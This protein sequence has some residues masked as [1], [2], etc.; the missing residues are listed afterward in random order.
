MHDLLVPMPAN[1]QQQTT[2]AVIPT[3]SPKLVPP[4]QPDFSPK[5]RCV[6]S[7]TTFVAAPRQTKPELSGGLLKL[8]DTLSPS[9]AKAYELVQ[10]DHDGTALNLLAFSNNL[11][12]A[13]MKK[14]KTP[15]TRP[16]Q[17]LP[18]LRSGGF[19]IA[20]TGRAA[21]LKDYFFNTK[22]KNAD[23]ESNLP[24]VLSAEDLVR[25]YAFDVFVSGRWYSLCSRLGS[26]HFT[27]TATT[28]PLV[29]EGWVSNPGVS[30]GTDG[31]SPD[32]KAHEAI[33]RWNG[34][35]LVAQRPGKTATVDEEPGYVTNKAETEFKVEITYEAAPDTLPPLR[36]GRDYHMRARAVDLAG[37]S[38]DAGSPTLADF[39]HALGDIYARFDPVS[40]PVLLM[41]APLTSSESLEHVVIRS[42]FDPVVGKALPAERHVAP[43]KVDEYMAEL[44]GMFDTP[45]GMNPGTYAA[46]V[47]RED[48]SFAEKDAQGNYVHPGA[49]KDD[50][51]SA[52]YF[53]VDSLS[54]P[55]EGGGSAKVPYLPDP[56]SRGVSFR[57]LPGLPPGQV[58][59][60]AFVQQGSGIEWPNTQP[61]RIRL[62]EGDLG[63]PTIL[64]GSVLEIIVPKA[65]VF[66]V[67][68]SSYLG[69]DDLT[70]MGI[71]QWITTTAGL[72][73]ADK[74]TLAKNATDGTHWM[75]TP[76]RKLFFVH[77]VRQPL[78][79][80]KFASLNADKQLGKTFATV[81][82][83]ST[84]T[85]RKSTQTLDVLASWTDVTD[86]LEGDVWQPEL[87]TEVNSLAFQ[88]LVALTDE[89][90]GDGKLEFSHLHEF[91]DTKYRS[92]DYSAVATTRFKQF[93]VE[94]HTIEFANTNAET[95]K[96]T[97]MG[98]AAGGVGVVEDSEQVKSLDGAVTFS[99]G[100][101]YTIDYNTG[102]ITR[103]PGGPGAMP[104]EVRV[105]FLVPPITRVTEAVTTRDVLNSA[106]PD[107]PR[108]LYVVPTF[109]WMPVV[110]GATKIESK[111]LGNGLRVYLDRP[112][113]SSGAGELLGVVLWPQ[114]APVSLVLPE[115]AKPFVTRWGMD[116]IWKST[117]TTPLP[118]LEDFT[119]SDAAMKQ[120]GLTLAELPPVGPKAAPPVSVAGH[121]VGFDL[122]RKLWY[123]DI[124][125][126]PGTS[127]FPF[128]R[129]A[130]ARYQPKSVPDAHLSR[131][132]LADFVQ[133]APD[134][135]ATITFDAVNAKLLKVSL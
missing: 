40:P 79:A 133:L 75:L 11:V 68:Y 59:P 13:L 81:S 127:Y 60:H 1:P 95:L 7:A 27:N 115:K 29:D 16:E 46:I 134:R 131:V 109:R 56:L 25:G 52:P 14:H 66:E 125:I 135:S 26:A 42:N 129:L 118:T 84:D 94:H 8:N 33:V 15:G 18:S 121:E 61:F 111:R 106:R 128:V 30:G 67:R 65:E 98:P 55:V 126:A 28:V 102:E 120:T 113:W 122:E 4:P 53:D 77:A 80:P 70:K 49:Q 32:L 48:G 23:L 76:F 117:A 72:S 38:G 58:F 6:V 90:L 116:P 74:A 123:C 100:T 63:P 50:N 107:A 47:A 96:N 44:L 35:S 5:T 3:W 9:G 112:W 51:N 19:T 99:R 110:D 93:F 10:V 101:D 89:K 87:S 124:D 85:S 54:F 83:N 132:V 43:P 78:V 31:F 69:P 82:D 17:S 45:T 37:N 57:G 34:W 20:K 36:F 88:I 2:V 104:S 108:V 71:W 130:L 97:W 62:V 41:R 64:P 39:T 119:A 22:K 103:I 24:L 92:V 21:F 114:G 105:D 86:H 73:D 91:H 12:R